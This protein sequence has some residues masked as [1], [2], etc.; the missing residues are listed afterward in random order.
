VG[1]V[2]GKTFKHRERYQD[3]RGTFSWL[4]KWN[5]DKQRNNILL[6]LGDTLWYIVLH[7]GIVYRPEGWTG[8]GRSCKTRNCSLPAS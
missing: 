4:E 8:V 6:M 2:R 7:A 3:R 1:K 5:L